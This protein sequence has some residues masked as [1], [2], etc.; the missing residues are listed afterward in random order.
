MRYL[1]VAALSLMLIAS[2]QSPAAAPAAPEAVAP[3]PRSV[4]QSAA[5]RP[6]AT[7]PGSSFAATSEIANLERNVEEIRD[8]LGVGKAT[9][10]QMQDA[11]IA[12][13]EARL[14]HAVVTGQRQQALQAL[15]A[16][17][18]AAEQKVQIVQERQQVGK[19]SGS[20][21]LEATQ[22]L[23][24]TQLRRAILR[25]Q[26]REALEAADRAVRT[27]Q[28][29]VEGLRERV[30]I[31]KVP[32]EDLAV[33]TRRLE[34]WRSLRRQQALVVEAQD[35]L[36]ALTGRSG[37]Q[38]D[39]KAVEGARADLAAARRQVYVHASLLMPAASDLLAGSLAGNSPLAGQDASRAPASVP[40]APS[41]QAAVSY[42]AP[43]NASAA[44]EQE[45]RQRLRGA[46]TSP[47]CQG[48]PGGPGLPADVRRLQQ[49][50]GHAGAGHRRSEARLLQVG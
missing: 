24:E 8:R 29:N 45:G 16:M 21:L 18:Q 31:G 2:C 47:G 42:P 44:T 48:Q 49:H 41:S 12:L 50:A 36:D 23:Y 25:D 19:A 30:Q 3:S 40:A 14:H 4:S 33:A 43:R 5:T 6:S 13:H 38:T 17:V 34:E 7:Q 15:D 37:G 32:P 9:D 22:A 35:R 10:V 28:Q 39:S 46:Q 1:C 27:Q 26:P 11:L 20:E